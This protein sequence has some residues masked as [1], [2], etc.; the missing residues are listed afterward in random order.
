VAVV[1]VQGRPFLGD[2]G[3]HPLQD[4]EEEASLME[5]ERDLEAA[6]NSCAVR[7]PEEGHACGTCL[8]LAQEALHMVMVHIQGLEACGHLY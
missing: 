7:I 6:L 2:F 5:C 8:M 1:Q 4:G 3:F